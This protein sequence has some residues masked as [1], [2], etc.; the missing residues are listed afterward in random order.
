[1]S[2]VVGTGSLSAIP[3]MA[4]PS[5]I[6]RMRR[7]KLL[8][9]G[10]LVVAL[11]VTSIAFARYYF[12]QEDPLP[13]IDVVEKGRIIPPGFTFTMNGGPNKEL[14]LSKPQAIA[15]HPNNGNI[16]ATSFVRDVIKGKIEVFR[17]DGTY[18]FTFD[19]IG[20]GPD[21]KPMTL[22]APLSIAIN[23]KGNV[24]VSDQAYNSIYIFSENG[25]FIST[26]A[27]NNDPKFEWAPTGMAFDNEGN[28][29]VT[30]VLKVHRVLVFDPTGKLK[31]EFGS[32]GMTVRKGEY[33][34]KFYFPNG[35][36]ID[37]DKKIFVAD[38]NN[39]RVQVFSPEGKFLYIIETGGLPRGI[40]ID[41]Q[42]RLY[43]VD[44]LG[45]N[46]TVYNKTSK[47]ARSL[48]I[49]GEQGT[50]FGQFLYPNGIALDKGGHRIFV[51][52]RENNRIQ[53]WT[54]P[55]VAAAVTPAVKKALPLGLILAA[56]AALIAWRMIR[57][58]RYFASSSFLNEII[59]DHQL[60]NLKKAVR[61]VYVHPATYE[62]L[63]KYTEGD[64]VGE[65]VLR[66]FKID[67]TQTASLKAH[68]D[69]DNEAAAL[70]AEAGKGWIKP[71]ILTNDPQNHAA[72]RKLSLESMDY[73][74]FLGYFEPKK[75]A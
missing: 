41:D 17:P 26:F 59:A 12:N 51:T 15:V 3:T 7:R 45:H 66:P 34:G 40:A 11:L 16:Y 62:K 60:Y 36:F 75:H 56:I 30:D 74:L 10:I 70:F 67:Q 14:A 48:A 61:K 19:Q 69:L 53:A 71:R 8:L 44:A 27:P 5:Y 47:D 38:S 35:L 58:R 28:L 37:R 22:K 21:K 9:I 65:D 73:Q 68:E 50:Q 64:I 18:Q 46:V 13:T 57:K 43:V 23:N 63:K 39:R 1:M 6:E 31:L 32:T 49:F 29:Y 4:L 52:D 33:P 72:A 54:W 42:N 24:Y 2:E 25:K 55:V 20:N